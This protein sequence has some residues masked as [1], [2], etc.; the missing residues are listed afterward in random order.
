MKVF[1]LTLRFFWIWLPLLLISCG[2][3]VLPE[4]SGQINSTDLPPI[5]YPITVTPYPTSTL[6]PCGYF[7]TPS[8]PIPTVPPALKAQQLFTPLPDQGVRVENVEEIF[9][10]KASLTSQSQEETCLE[11]LMISDLEGNILVAATVVPDGQT[12]ITIDVETGE[13]Q[14]ISQV[15]E[16]GIEYLKISGQYIIWTE[17]TPDL[18][19][20]Q[21]RLQLFDLE[22]HQ[23]TTLQEGSFRYLDIK[24]DLLVWQDFGGQSWNI[25]GYDLRT[26]QV[27]TMIESPLFQTIPHICSE[28]WV[29]Y[30]QDE[31]NSQAE[32]NS[33]MM[34]DLYAYHLPTDETIL[35][36]QV[37][38]RNDAMFGQFHDCDGQYVAWINGNFEDATLKLHDASTGAFQ[39]E[40]QQV[41]HAHH[42]YNLTTRTDRILNMQPSLSRVQ[43]DGD[44]LPGYD[45]QRDAYFDTIPAYVP[46]EDRMGGP[47][48]FSKNR[49][50]WMASP[51]YA[52]RKLFAATITHD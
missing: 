17:P 42:L 16:Q 31:P 29:I 51:D 47:L 40:T 50:V 38:A 12:V 10:S 21:S 28:E 34:I 13:V 15:I 20:F 14:Q 1:N 25:Y 18:G 33:Q 19:D 6:T 24:D 41:I 32:L 36:G 2:P 43:I 8:H 9:I 4:E 35:I 39:T 11:R 45:I 27:F 48:L 22:Q 30:L 44:I 49:V 23:Q 37:P 46:L 5:E 7:P 3:V 26:K 52:P